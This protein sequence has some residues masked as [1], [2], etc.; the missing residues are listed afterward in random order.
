MTFGGRGFWTNIGTL[1]QS[2]VDRVVNR[3]LDAGVNFIHTADVYSEG[4]AE[5][6]VSALPPEYPGWMIE[7]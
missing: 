7:G 3:A 4:L 5:D 6:H 2:V 1:D